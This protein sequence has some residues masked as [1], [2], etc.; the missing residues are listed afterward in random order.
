MIKCKNP[1]PLDRFEGCCFECDLKET[2]EE[3][4]ELIPSECSDS[5]MD[6]VSE[7]TG[8]QAFKQGQMAV[9]KQIADIITTK[10]KLEEQEAE[11]K[12]KLKEAMEKYNIKKFE[13]DILDIT[14]VAESTKT[15]IDSTK[16]KKKYPEIAAECS[17]SIKTSAY[18]KVTV[19]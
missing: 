12:V 7:E 11:L 1:C 13:S 8:L 3:A 18:V 5:I 19:K 17:K 15:S 9:L 4:C 2:C 16:L 6:E 14:Y 10:K